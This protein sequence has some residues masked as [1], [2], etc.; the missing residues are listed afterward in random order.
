MSCYAELQV[1]SN[2]SFLRGASHPEELVAKAAELGLS[3]IAITDRNTL[4]G[5]VRAH[6]AAKQAGI[7]FV[8]GTRLDLEDAPSLLCFPTDRAAYGRL[9]RLLTVGRRRAPKGECRLGLT[10]VFDHGEGQIVVAI[11]PREPT[12]AFSD[13]LSMVRSHFGKSLY[14]SASKSY[15]GDDSRRLAMLAN[16]ADAN[17]VPLVATND[18]H[19]HAAHRKALQDV[20]TCIREHCTI[21]DAGHRLFANAERHL[22]P[23]AEMARLFERYPRAI[24]HTAEIAEKCAFT[25]DELR[26]EYPVDPVPG[27]GTPQ[28]ELARMTWAGAAERYPG[29]V[30]DKVRTQVT[31]ELALIETLGFAPYFLTVHDIV[32]FARERGHSLSGTR[33]GGQ[34]GGLLRSGNHRGGSGPSGFSV[35]TVHQRRT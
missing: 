5:L 24:T 18:V 16:L 32:R 26:Y 4:A 30:P 31:H 23:P 8:V 13:A 1:S 35:R 22:K 11:P 9:S 29:G 17:R 15:L 28:D 27:G 10:D 7:K 20:L 3:A 34:F 6:G 21:Y 25:L 14:L 19:A 2:F 33:L 12:E